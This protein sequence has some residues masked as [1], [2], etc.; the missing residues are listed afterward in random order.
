MGSP[1]RLGAL[2]GRQVGDLGARPSVPLSQEREG[3]EASGRQRLE[4]PKERKAGKELQM[5]V[6]EPDDEA[7]SLPRGCSDRARS[8]QEQV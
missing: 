8:V 4:E 1:G 3:H 2:Q 5:S 7:V 6:K